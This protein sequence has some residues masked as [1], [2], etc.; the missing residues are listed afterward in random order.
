MVQIVGEKNATLAAGKPSIA[1]AGNTVRDV[2]EEV[3]PRSPSV[4]LADAIASHLWKQLWFARVADETGH[5]G[6]E[7]VVRIASSSH[8]QVTGWYRDLQKF[9]DAIL[10]AT[11]EVQGDR[12]ST[13]YQGNLVA[14][15]KKEII[16]DDWFPIPPQSFVDY[17][18]AD[19]EPEVAIP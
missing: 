15:I 4:E 19:R 12:L 6:I 11:V 2:G 1:R 5:R 9:A 3:T 7:H 13:E 17:Q 18:F 10:A 14:E 8:E 16:A